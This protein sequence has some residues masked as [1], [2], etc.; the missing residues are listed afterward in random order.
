MSNYSYVCRCG[1]LV[2]D[3]M[4]GDIKLGRMR[5]R[6]YEKESFKYLRILYIRC[7]MGLF[8]SI[9]RLS[10]LAGLAVQFC[11]FYVIA[12]LFYRYNLL[13]WATCMSDELPLTPAAELLLI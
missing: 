12:T 13:V 5:I 8:M 10:G 7:R 11:N 6:S 3:I 9:Y 2:E 1:N 4:N